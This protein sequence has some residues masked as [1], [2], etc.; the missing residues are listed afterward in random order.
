MWSGLLTERMERNLLVI[1]RLPKTSVRTPRLP[2]PAAVF[3]H[4]RTAQATACSQP[5]PPLEV[6]H[7]DPRPRHPPV[8]IIRQKRAKWRLQSNGQLGMAPQSGA[9]PTPGLPPQQH[10]RSQVPSS[11]RVEFLRWPC[12][13]Q[14]IAQL[15]RE[16]RCR[17]SAE[18]VD[19]LGSFAEL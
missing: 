19:E 13:S 12:T 8:V 5:S 15:R 16:P 9:A 4:H 10:H 14:G 3:G 7:R 6:L 1:S 2:V 17:D 11:V 18:F